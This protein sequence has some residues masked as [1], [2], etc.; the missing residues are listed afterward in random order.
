MEGHKEDLLLLLDHDSELPLLSVHVFG[1]LLEFLSA[2]GSLQV[3]WLLFEF[4]HAHNVSL[5]LMV[6]DLHG[7]VTYLVVWQELMELSEVRVGLEDVQQ[8]QSQVDWL[9]VVVTKRT[10]HSSEQC[11]VIK[12]D[13]HVLMREAQIKN[14]HGTLSLLFILLIV[15]HLQVVVKV[16]DVHLG[17]VN[18]WS[19]LLL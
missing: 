10:R 11:L 13:L 8:I 16:A 5:D 4:T 19:S 7:R 12:H 15:E 1:H 14:G 17:E 9:F 2:F 3:F 6:D 18:L